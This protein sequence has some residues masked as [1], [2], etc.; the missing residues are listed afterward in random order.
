MMMSMKGRHRERRS[1]PDS[2][3][4]TESNRYLSKAGGY[5]RV[6]PSVYPAM[7]IVTVKPITAIKS[8]ISIRLAPF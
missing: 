5:F 3:I 1:A 8:I 7:K 2:L 4:V 6:L